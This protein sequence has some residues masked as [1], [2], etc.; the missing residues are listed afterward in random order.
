MATAVLLLAA[1]AAAGMPQAA[2]TTLQSDIDALC[3][4]VIAGTLTEHSGG[5]GEPWGC[6][7]VGTDPCDNPPSVGGP[8]GVWIGITCSGSAGDIDRRITGM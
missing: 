2:A 7:L 6:G 1:L 4:P 3:A 8:G 5:D